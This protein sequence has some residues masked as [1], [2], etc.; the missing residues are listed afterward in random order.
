MS[1]A[2]PVQIYRQEAA[3]LLE[4]LEQA[5]L[6]LERDPGEA[7]LIN[8]A[9]RALHTL[10]GSGAMFGFDAVAEFTHHVETAFDRAS[11]NG[12]VAASV[13]LIEVAL[14]AKDQIRRLIE[15]PTAPIRPRVRRSWTGWEPSCRAHPMPRHG[16]RR[17]CHGACTS[18]CRTTRWRWGRTRCCCSMNCAR[19]GTCAVVAAVTAVPP[20]EAP[21]SDGVPYWL[22]RHTGDRAAAVRPSSRSSCSCSTRCNSTSSRSRAP[23]RRSRNVAAVPNVPAPPN[24]PV[25]R[26]VPGAR[27]RSGVPA[28][29]PEAKLALASP[30]AGTA[31]MSVTS[32]QQHPRAGRTPG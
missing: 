15:Q 18:A 9:F 4:Q 13:P 29:A 19:W 12:E 20:L 3:E 28:N 17:S 32:Q 6:D 8:T 27:R 26:G 5:L 10:K 14:A 21:G 31:A 23:C 1:G 22:G 16:M 24:L 25:A 11:R 7:D 30:R 2:D